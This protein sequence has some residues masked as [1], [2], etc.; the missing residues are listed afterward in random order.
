ML[1][2]RQST[3]S[4][5]NLIDLDP[6]V[7]RQKSDRHGRSGL[8]RPRGTHGSLLSATLPAAL[9]LSVVRTGRQTAD[10]SRSG[11]RQ[12]RQAHDARPPP[13][14]PRRVAEPDAL[15]LRITHSLCLGPPEAGQ[16]SALPMRLAATPLAL[17]VPSA[18]VPPPPRRRRHRC[19]GVQNP[20]T[21]CAWMDD[22][23]VRDREVCWSPIAFLSKTPDGEYMSKPA[24][25]ST[26]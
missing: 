12:G 18:P 9:A 21:G 16:G 7:K 1:L 2:T 10:P 15:L 8:P 20:S 17:L 5:R 14:C 22:E 23:Y 6:H 13:M 25:H 19:T 11:S 26:P 4:A 3:C 24:R